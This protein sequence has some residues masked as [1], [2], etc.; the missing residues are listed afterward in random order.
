[1]FLTDFGDVRIYPMSQ[2]KDAHT[3]LPYIFIDFGVP[4]LIHSDNAWEIIKSKEWKKILEEEGFIKLY[5]IEPHSNFQEN[6]RREI[7]QSQ[8]L[9]LIQTK[10][11][12]VTIHLWD[13]TFVYHV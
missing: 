4:E 13:N 3:S 11:Y 8:R 6:T 12:D 5:Q 7:Q 2:R 9:S 10:L 1:M